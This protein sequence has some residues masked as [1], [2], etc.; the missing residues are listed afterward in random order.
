MFSVPLSVLSLLRAGSK[1]FFFALHPFDKSYCLFN[2]LRFFGV[3]FDCFEYCLKFLIRHSFVN[4]LIQV[5]S[6]PFCQDFSLLT[7]LLYAYLGILSSIF[8]RIA[9]KKDP[10]RGLLV[11]S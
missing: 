11:L 3:F 8:Q 5:F 7:S 2:A 9:R 1:L 4:L 10:F 6:P